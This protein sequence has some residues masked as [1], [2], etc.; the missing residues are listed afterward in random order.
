MAADITSTAPALWTGTVT[1]LAELILKILSV[2]KCSLDQG[3]GTPDTVPRLDESGDV[4]I[5]YTGG[6]ACSTRGDRR[7]ELSTKLVFRQWRPPLVTS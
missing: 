3:L 5:E 4:L 2:T 1:R 6:G 7:E